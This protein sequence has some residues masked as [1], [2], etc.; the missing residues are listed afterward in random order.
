[1]LEK[2]L[3]QCDSYFSICKDRTTEQS[4][5]HA[6]LWAGPGLLCVL[7]NVLCA[8]PFMYRYYWSSP[9]LPIY[10]HNKCNII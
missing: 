8:D 10:A 9:N 2:Y 3:S 6:V 7:Y 4:L 1:M 5:S